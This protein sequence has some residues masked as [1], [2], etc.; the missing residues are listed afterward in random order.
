MGC[1]MPM[2][3]PFLDRPRISS[4]LP[5]SPPNSFESFELSK[6]PTRCGPSGRSVWKPIP[7]RVTV[8]LLP[9]PRSAAVPNVLDGA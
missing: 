1:A 8:A 7:M 6:S 3:A 9:T 2:G 4:C 5:E